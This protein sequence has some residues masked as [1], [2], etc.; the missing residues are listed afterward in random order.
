MGVV[1]DIYTKQPFLK[2]LIDNIHHIVLLAVL[3]MHL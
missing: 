3:N 2:Q 1:W